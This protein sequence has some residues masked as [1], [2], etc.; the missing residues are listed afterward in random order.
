[1]GSPSNAN[2]FFFFK[3]IELNKHRHVYIIVANSKQLATKLIVFVKYQEVCDFTLYI[4]CC[5]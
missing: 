4:L 5:T 1:M 3:R 2:E